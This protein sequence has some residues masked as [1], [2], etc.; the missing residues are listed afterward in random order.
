MVSQFSGIFFI[1]ISFVF[2]S[3]KFMICCAGKCDVFAERLGWLDSKCFSA[4][5]DTEGVK[6]RFR[7]LREEKLFALTTKVAS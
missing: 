2:S 4:S 1:E 7:L 6:K 5:S 3:V